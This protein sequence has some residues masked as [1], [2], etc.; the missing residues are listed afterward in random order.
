MALF[1]FDNVRIAGI[2][3]AVPKNIKET[4]KLSCFS[5]AEE[6]DRVVKMSCVEEA[7]IVSDGQTASD[8]CYEA[9]EK[10]ISE[11]NWDKSEVG[12]LVY[13]TFS[14]DYVT[15]PNTSNILQNR[16]GLPIECM[17]IDLPQ[18][19]PGYIYG[20]NVVS[21]L[22]QAGTLKKAL[23]LV[24]ETNSKAH[25]SMDKSIYPLIGDAGTATALVYDKNADTI[26]I[27]VA[28]DGSEAEYLIAPDG[29]ARN[30][31][32][33]DSL[34]VVEDEP[35]M[36]RNKL[37]IRMDGMEVFRF[38]ISSPVSS[39][40][41]LCASYDINLNA[42]DYLVLHQA[43]KY[44]DEKIA[45]KLGVPLEK[46]PFSLMK[47]GNPSGCSIPLTII[48]NLREKVSASKLDLVLC[49]FGAGLSWGSAHVKLDSIVCPEIIEC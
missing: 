33:V 23:L 5:D 20:L 11:L 31:T 22:F 4:R 9:A 10:L 6:A 28:A 44:I 19:C 32:T 42:V 2:S 17:A 3:A 15:V 30:P 40:Q 41:T 35:G 49:G 16:L 26:Q 13:V 43:N 29:G 48:N 36:F 37:H 38:S 27:H 24:G 45:H 25:S 34:K 46:V 1:S 8:L 18:A 21:A 14:R 47:Y 7:R 39:V 12:L